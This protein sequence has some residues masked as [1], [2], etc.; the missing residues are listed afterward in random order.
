MLRAACAFALLLG[1]HSDQT[2]YVQVEILPPDAPGADSAADVADR[3]VDAVTDTDSSLHSSGFLA[4]DAAEQ[5]RVETSATRP[6]VD[7]ESDGDVHVAAVDNVD[8]DAGGSLRAR[9]VDEID[10][11]SH[12]ALYL[13]LRSSWPNIALFPSIVAIDFQNSPILNSQQRNFQLQL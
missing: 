3:L 11:Y 1:S 13:R 8:I 5:V 12:P 6:A 7:V 4:F 10:D 2:Y 9:I